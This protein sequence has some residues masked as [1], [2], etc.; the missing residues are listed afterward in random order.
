MKAKRNGY[1][2]FFII[3]GISI[4]FLLISLIIKLCGIST[5]TFSYFWIG[6]TMTIVT[7]LP[8][9]FIKKKIYLYLPPFLEFCYYLFFLTFYLF[10]DPFFM[11]RHPISFFQ[12]LF[13]FPSLN[14][15][16]ILLTI[17]YIKDGRSNES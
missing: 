9:L 3:N 11:F 1:I 10:L 12:A 14:A 7:S 4:T 16:Y 5:S 8:F 2:L 17:L 15:F 6:P 13:Y